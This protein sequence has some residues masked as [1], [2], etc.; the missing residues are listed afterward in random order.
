MEDTTLLVLWLAT[1]WF[2]A[3]IIIGV[4]EGLKSANHILEDKLKKHLDNIIHRVRVEKD[5]DIY[6]WYDSDDN[7]FL[8]QGSTDEQVIE[9]LKT[10]YPTHIF[11]LPTNHIICKGTSWQLKQSS[12]NINA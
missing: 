2:L 1:T 9:M 5:K 8:A 11:Y 10:K 3:N 4:C 7:E 6:Y 12:I